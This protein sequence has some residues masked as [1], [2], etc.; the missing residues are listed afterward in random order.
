MKAKRVALILNVLASAAL[1]LV[2]TGAA[3]K[4][5]PSDG[6]I[7][8]AVV[9]NLAKTYG[10]RAKVAA[11]V[12]L[13]GPFGTQSQWTLVVAKQPDE[14]GRAG[15][16]EGAVSVCFVKGAEADCSDALFLA[17]FKKL[18]ITL[19]DGERPFH[20]LHEAR[21]VRADAST[22]LLSLKACT[23][24]S[25]NSD[26]A[27]STFL[28]AYDARHD[29]FR[30]VFSNMT[31]RNNN[32][33]TR[34]IESGPLQGAVV[35][36]TPTYKAPFVYE[37]DVYRPAADGQYRRVLRHRGRTVYGDGNPLPVIDSEMPALLGRFG[38]W[39]AGDALPVP[40]VLP[41]GCT[42]L[43]LRK[44]VEWCESKG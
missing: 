34:F 17:H 31:G 8:R 14:E 33:E 26:C 41:A 23:A 28:Y 37:L 5:P 25:F 1:A 36:A 16:L 10:A 42:R 19:L 11:H 18:G 12:D 7:D 9:E 32:Q 39:K 44:G 43:Y 2:A 4:A 27:V 21:V 40:P 22:P 38:H 15:P 24:Q 13:I 6:D 35:V 30:P 29:R 20:E 3:A